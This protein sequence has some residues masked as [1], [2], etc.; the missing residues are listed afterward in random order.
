MRVRTRPLLPERLAPLVYGVIQAAITT[1]AGTAVAALNAAPK[2]EVLPVFWLKCW[3]LS[4]IAVLP[5]VILLSP[6]IQRIV[7]ALTRPPLG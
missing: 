7:L 2:T 5:I 4:W 1:G 6:L 3:L